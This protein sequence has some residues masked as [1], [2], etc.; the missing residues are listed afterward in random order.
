MRWAPKGLDIAGLINPGR[1]FSASPMPF[2]GWLEP[3][4]PVKGRA[5]LC[6]WG[7]RRE[8]NLTRPGDGELL[9]NGAVCQASEARCGIL[10]C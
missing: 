5:L 4:A 1:A 2:G 7:R 9:S 8:P 6:L 10:I 3:F